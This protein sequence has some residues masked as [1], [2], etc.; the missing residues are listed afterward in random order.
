[1]FRIIPS[2]TIFSIGRV[3][4]EAGS[5]KCSKLEKAIILNSKCNSNYKATI[6][7]CMQTIICNGI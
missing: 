3:G 2:V 6:N 5:R 1:M 7:A 4:T